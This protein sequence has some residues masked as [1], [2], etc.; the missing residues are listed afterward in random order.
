[1]T[2]N[3]AIDKNI[4]KIRKPYWANPDAYL[5][6]HLLGNGTRGPWVELYDEPCQRVIGEPTPQRFP[7]FELEE[8]SAE[9][10]EKGLS[11]KNKY[12]MDDWE[13]YQPKPK[14]LV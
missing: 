8:R 4:A 12:R 1:M 13:E 6:L 10:E 2:V 7:F 9:A 5:K 11:M 3:E 14:P